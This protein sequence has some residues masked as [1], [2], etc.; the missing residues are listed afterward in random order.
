MKRR[1]YTIATILLIAM[2]AVSPV[3][4]LGQVKIATSPGSIKADGFAAGFTK[5]DAVKITLEGK[6]FAYASCID[7]GDNGNVVPGQNP[8]V[9]VDSMAT[10]YATTDQDGKVEVHLEAQP[11][12]SPVDVG[13]PNKN[14]IV[15]IDWVDWYWAAIT[16]YDIGAGEPGVQVYYQAYNCVSNRDKNTVTCKAT[17]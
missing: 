4:A 1:I 9:E 11:V 5:F 13:C 10:D 7:P 16:V 17:R 14:W 2:L 12:L 6:G 3:A 15:H 8:I